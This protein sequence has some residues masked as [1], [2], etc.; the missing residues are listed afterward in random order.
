[1]P[2]SPI[3]VGTILATLAALAFGVTTPFIQRFGAGVGPFV[4]ASL[5]YLGAALGAVGRPRGATGRREAAVRL[6][7]LPR[8][9]AASLLGQP[10]WAFRH[11]EQQ[12]EKARGRHDQ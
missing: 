10:A 4:T 8:L 3:A 9:L 6:R 5:L 1:M 12:Q 11:P 2:R 7:H